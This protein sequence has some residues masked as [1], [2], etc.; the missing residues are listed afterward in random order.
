MSALRKVLVVDDDPVVG[1]SFNRVLT[2]K[3][4]YVVVTAQNAHEALER[5]RE[6]IYDVVFTDIKMPGMDGVEL[7]ETV[8]SR[9][10]WIPIV[11]VTGY[12][13]VD[14]EDRA[15]AAGV[16]AF[17]RK[18]LSPEMIEESAHDAL[19]QPVAAPVSQVFVADAA[20]QSV[21]ITP[22]AARGNAKGIALAMVSP[23]IGLAFA[24]LMPLVGLATLA[25]VAMSAMAANPLVRKGAMHLKNIA[26]FLAAPFIGLAYALSLPLVGVGMLAWIGWQAFASSPKYSKTAGTLKQAGLFVAAPFIGLVFA[27]LLPVVGTAMLV[28]VG[29]SGL[30]DAPQVQ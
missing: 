3:K 10:P 23:L 7:A 15:K 27:V 22:A 5:M 16:S 4:G 13:T 21:Q 14:N 6:E 25:W 29:L 18:P 2:D 24:V 26:L 8:K 17:L 28:W 11:I 20:P 9:Q 1:K 19:L 12:G 30:M